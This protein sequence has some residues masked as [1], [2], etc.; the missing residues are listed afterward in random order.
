MRAANESSGPKSKSQP[1]LVRLA[2]V[3]DRAFQCPWSVIDRCGDDAERD[4]RRIEG[5]VP[6][7]GHRV[8]HGRRAMHE[9]DRTERGL[10]RRTSSQ[11]EARARANRDAP[12]RRELHE[13]IMR[14]LII[15]KGLALERFADLEELAIAFLTDGQRIEAQHRVDR[16]VRA[17]HV[18]A[19][20]SHPPV[21]NAELVAPAW[22]RLMVEESI[23]DAVLHDV[24]VSGFRLGECGNGKR[25]TC[26]QC[27]GGNPFNEHR[28]LLTGTPT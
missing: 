8:F 19:E 28:V 14:V 27:D 7:R 12:H 10:C 9:C 20:H 6:E 25:H 18:A 21:G 16:E 23:Y 17:A 5:V 1:I 22:R 15:D 3:E 13:Q 4:V 2:S 11:R 26:R 24:P